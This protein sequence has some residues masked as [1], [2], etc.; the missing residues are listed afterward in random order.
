M[1]TLDCLGRRCPVPVIELAKALP[2][3]EVGD[4]IEVLSDDP[5]SA[6]DIP[7]WCRMRGQGFEGG[8]APSYLVRRLS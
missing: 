6:N 2:N 8:S 5:A 1:K 4:L 3:L 7:A